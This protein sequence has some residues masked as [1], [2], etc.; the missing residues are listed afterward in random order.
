MSRSSASLFFRKLATLFWLCLLVTC[1]GCGSDLEEPQ[2]TSTATNTP[3]A[4]STAT[5]TPLPTV[6][7][8]PSRTPTPSRTPFPTSSPTP[9]ETPAPPYA[10]ELWLKRD[11]NGKLIDW[12]YSHIT[13]IGWN[14][15][16]EVNRFS[17]TLGFQLMDRAIH[18]DTIT[19]FAKPL[20][21]YYLNVRHQVGNDLENT[22]LIVGGAF[23]ED[24]P[25]GIIPA[26]GPSY[27]KLKIMTRNEPFDPYFSHKTASL[28]YEERRAEYPDT[29]LTDLE[30]VLANL[31][32]QV[33]LLADQAI[34][35]D[36]DSVQRFEYDIQT[37]S[38]LVARYYPWMVLDDYE[39]F[40][41]ANQ[42]AL[43]LANSLYLNKPI[44]DPIELYSGDTL[45]FITG[46]K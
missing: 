24:I 42:A 38:Y 8:R 7:P 32:D 6:T 10:A 26:G 22:R 23:G 31:P 21:V 17:A 35:I 4:T 2:P 20:T 45:I 16:G 29:L 13:D 15:K 39:R 28:P 40:T 25:L 14:S 46:T 33:I 11:I 1:Y 44:S 3:T 19:V 34:I 27:V 12:G 9:T 30:Q 5:V 18:R 43:A 37:V 41:G 36:P